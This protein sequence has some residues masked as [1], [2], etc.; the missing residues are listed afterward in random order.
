MGVGPPRF[1][2]CGGPDPGTPTV[3]TPMEVAQPKL[4]LQNFGQKVH[5]SPISSKI[6]KT[7]S[8][9]KIVDQ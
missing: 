9:Y 2:S 5:F 4:K 1:E 6:L 7:I 8:Q 3:V